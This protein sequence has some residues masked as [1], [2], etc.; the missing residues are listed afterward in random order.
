MGKF[1][2]GKQTLIPSEPSGDKRFTDRNYLILNSNFT[3]LI[4]SIKYRA[5]QTPELGR[6]LKDKGYK[7]M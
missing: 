1:N 4:E 3:S 5:L 6:I 7:N 2:I